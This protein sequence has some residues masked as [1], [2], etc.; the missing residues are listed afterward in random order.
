[1]QWSLFFV[2]F[3]FSIPSHFIFLSFFYAFIHFSKIVSKRRKAHLRRLDRRWTLGGM[4]NRQQSRG[5]HFSGLWSLERCTCWLLLLLLL[6]D[7][8]RMAGSYISFD[9]AL[10]PCSRGIK[11]IRDTCV[12]TNNCSGSLIYTETWIVENLFLYLFKGMFLLASYRKIYLPFSTFK[13]FCLK[14]H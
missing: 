12:F 4:V 6:S 2:Q 9:G 5:E 8:L 14:L 11:V 13:F 3:V 7:L 10:F 1:M